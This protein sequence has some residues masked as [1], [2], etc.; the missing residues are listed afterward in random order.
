MVRRIG[1]AVLLATLASGPVVLRAKPNDVPT[2]PEAEFK[3]LPTISV[4]HFQVEITGSDGPVS[5]PML[6]SE[7][8]GAPIAAVVGCGWSAVWFDAIVN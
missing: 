3:V 1:L 7:K 8:P 2:D 4:D 5:V 6:V